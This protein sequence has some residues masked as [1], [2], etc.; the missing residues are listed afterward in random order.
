MKIEA[1]EK[2]LEE[3][4]KLSCKNTT[5]AI[6]LVFKYN[7]VSVNLYFD[8]YDEDAPS[9][10][11]ILAYDKDYYYTSLNVK[12]TNITKEYLVEIPKNILIKI[13]DV[14]NQLDDFF[15]EIDEH[16]LSSESEFRPIN[17]GRDIV[18]TNT[19]KYNRGRKD[20]PFLH[21]TKK[22]PMKDDTLNNLSATM[23]IDKDILLKIQKEKM[24][25]V[26]TDD[27]KK[28]KKLTAILQGTNVKI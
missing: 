2:L 4:S 16:I 7:N 1:K 3:Y 19:L 5:T 22:V 18:F 8:A 9:L 17:Y 28:R 21:Y 10:S 6:K 25:L 13:L 24:T 27:T 11:M 14:N 15:T 23:G 12:N 20:L 26:R